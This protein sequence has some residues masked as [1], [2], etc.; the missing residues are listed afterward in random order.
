LGEH[1]IA[2]I[3]T[4]VQDLDAAARTYANQLQW[5][6]HVTGCERVLF[7]VEHRHTLRR[8]FRWIGRDAARIALLAEHEDAFLAEP[9]ARRAAW[10]ARDQQEEA[11]AHWWDE[12]AAETVPA[13]EGWPAQA[14]A[15][16]RVG[17]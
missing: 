3:K 4:S 1:S 15:Q 7:V 10:L 8:D 6:L 13:P 2:E 16:V 17:T 5:Q 12:R 9:D 14:P 11:V